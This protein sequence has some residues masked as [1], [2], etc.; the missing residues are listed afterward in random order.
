MEIT[1]VEK[2]KNKNSKCSIIICV[3]FC[4]LLFG[5]S[6]LSIVTPTK[7]FSENENRF[8][9][10]KPKFTKENFLSGKYAT[11]YETFITDQFPARNQWITLKTWTERIL[12]KQESNGVYFGKDDYLIETHQAS[13]LD[14]EQLATNT[15][16]LIEFLSK[17]TKLLGKEHVKMMLVPTAN[18]ILTDKLPPF[19]T[20]FD[21][22]AYLE[23][24]NEKLSKEQIEQ[25]QV[26]V[27]DILLEHKK[28]D[29]FYR[30]DHHWTA[31]GAYYAYTVWAKSCGF[32]LAPLESYNKTE[33][34]N[35]FYGTIYSKVN[36]KVKPDTIVIYEPKEEKK[37]QVEYNLGEKTT[38]TLYEMEQ[39]KGKD[40]YAIFLGGN[41][42]VVKIKQYPSRAERGK[43][44]IIK[45]SYAHCF[46]PFVLEHYQEVEMID[47]RY[48]NMSVLE[49]IDM[50]G[51]DDVLFLY[52]IPNFAKDRNM[53]NLR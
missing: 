39:L 13:D 49:Y 7:S 24:V 47:L 1:E 23:Q 15:E 42:A 22:F 26:D 44:L 34:S 37:Y 46:T 36:I 3:V 21:Q 33:I 51:Y 20:G 38:D 41:N 11:E 10:K 9:T 2:E 19:A 18:M 48:F 53:S 27:S 4:L 30:T 8:L 29:I 50:N 31:L 5:M 14:T 52:N 12:L 40:K 32:D 45:D 6:F 16:R 28:E 17:A 35:D 43:L 25:V